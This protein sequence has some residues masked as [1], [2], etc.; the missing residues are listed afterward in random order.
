M[1]PDEDTG[2]AV[3][4]G[5]RVRVQLPCAKYVYIPVRCST[6][7]EYVP[8]CAQ[9]FSHF[10]FDTINI[11][12]TVYELLCGCWVSDWCCAVLCCAVLCCAVLCCAVLW[13]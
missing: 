2:I 9:Q 5:L 3:D 6:V 8:L 7:P 1:G 12:G 11:Y 4:Y 10:D 13:L